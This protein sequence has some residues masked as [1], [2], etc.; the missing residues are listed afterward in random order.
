LDYA[1][2]FVDAHYLGA[3]PEKIKD[4]I[5]YEM[6]KEAIFS[7]DYFSLEAGGKCHVFSRH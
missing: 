2:H 5:D 3:T 6:F 4:F 7:H 1:I